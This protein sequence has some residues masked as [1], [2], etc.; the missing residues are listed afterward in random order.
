MNDLRT[1][2]IPK[3]TDGEKFEYLIRDIY[4]NNSEYE[5]VELNGRRGQSQQGVDI[6]ARKEATGEWIG[7]QC[8]CRAKGKNLSRS[9]IE[10]EIKKAKDFNPKI[11][12]LYIYTTC[13]R[14][15]KVQEITREI[16][17]T[18]IEEKS[19]KIKVNFWP[20]I[21]ESLKDEANFPVYYRFYNKFFADNL[22]LGHAVSKLF[23]LNLHFDNNPDTHCELM[24]GRIPNYK[25]DTHKNVD[26][27]RG[28]YF[29]A[30]LLHDRIETFTLPCFDSD[31]AEAFPNKID[32]HRVC[33]W[34][35]SL[36]NI[37]EFIAS[38]KKT[39]VF[40]LN[41]EERL[42]FMEESEEYE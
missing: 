21:E 33:K 31:I 16:N 41:H 27:Y 4:R 13:D 25:D 11:S 8:K 37:E 1:L 39:Y 23:N 29:I 14:D 30:N 34:I 10:L 26:Y 22:T 42:A 9:D 15:V 36:S 3:I 12:T 35:N 28:T 17:I 32:R 2:D 38:D 7:I 20:D 24:L 6:F 40:S 19:F 18:L 5:F